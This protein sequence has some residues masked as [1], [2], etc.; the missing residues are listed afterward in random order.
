MKVLVTGGSGFV[1]KRLQKFK[2]D[3][4]YASSKDVDLT[5]YGDC[6]AYIRKV[7]PDA[8]VHL[9]AKVGGIKDNSEHTPWSC[10]RSPPVNKSKRK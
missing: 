4:I 9:A 8:V 3:W 5:N 2:P 7:C 1:G 10:H 6:L